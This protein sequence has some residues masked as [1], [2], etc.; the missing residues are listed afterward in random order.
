MVDAK[1]LDGRWREEM[2]TCSRS[3]SRAVMTWRRRDGGFFGEVLLEAHVF[4]APGRGFDRN[5]LI[6]VVGEVV[7]RGSHIEFAQ[8]EGEKEGGAEKVGAEP[9]HG[10]EG[11]LVEIHIGVDAAGLFVILAGV[12]GRLQS[13]EG[14][15]CRSEKAHRVEVRAGE[16]LGVDE[17]LDGGIAQA[18]RS[19]FAVPG[20][21]ALI[22]H[23]PFMQS[24]AAEVGGP[25]GGFF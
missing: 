18:Q 16:G 17:V 4:G 6:A 8:F 20:I 23:R 5:G 14:L 3:L 24:V 12:E 10:L 25:L 1:F 21:V 22:N 9:W 15:G 13:I 2:V 7:G 11:P 19:T